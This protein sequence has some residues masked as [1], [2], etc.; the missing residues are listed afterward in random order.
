MEMS[1]REGLANSKAVCIACTQM[2]TSNGRDNGVYFTLYTMTCHTV[3]AGVRTKR[4]TIC[5]EKLGFSFKF[6]FIIY[7]DKLR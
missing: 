7:G 4:N 1:N 6:K 3:I 2:H 5:A